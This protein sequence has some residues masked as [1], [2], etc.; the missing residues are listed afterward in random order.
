[1]R[2]AALLIC[3]TGMDGSGKTTHAYSI[4]KHLK[5]RGY[6]CKYS[7]AAFRPFLS[8]SFFVFTRI[9]GYWKEKKKN[10]YTD[11]LEYAPKELAKK[12]A[13]IWQLFLFLD[14][15]IRTTIKIRLPLALGITIIC[16]RY[17][18]DLFIELQRSNL[19]NNKFIK[20]LTTTLPRPTL[21]FLMDVSEEFVSK[22]RRL[23]I[24]EIREKRKFY[25]E[26]AKSFRFIIVNSAGEFWSNQKKIRSMI[27]VYLGKVN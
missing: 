24:N 2:K 16:D 5:K 23:L 8:Y 6:A 14:F 25:L 27:E 20:L 21:T 7:W 9:L 19:L 15:Q 22:R 26:M 10:T 3:F 11:P 12:L 1:M 17:I 13:K 4:L 18:Y